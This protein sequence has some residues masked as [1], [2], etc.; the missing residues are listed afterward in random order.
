MP[1]TS[2]PRSRRSNAAVEARILSALKTERVAASKRARGPSPE[3]RGDRARLIDGRAP[4]ALRLQDHVVCARHGD[5]A[6][7]VEGIWLRH[8]SGRGREDLARRLHHPREPS[9]RHPARVRARRRRSSTCCWTTRS[10]MRSASA[11]T[12]GAT[13]CRRRSGS[14]FRSG[15]GVVARLLRY[16][17][18]QPACRPTYA[19]RSG[20]SSA[21]TPIAASIATA[22]STRTGRA[23]PLTTQKGAT[24][25]DDRRIRSAERAR[26]RAP[27][28][29][30]RS[31]RSSIASIRA[32]S[33]SARRSTCEIHVSGGEFNVAA[34]LADCF[35]LKTG[36]A[37]AMVEYP[38]GELIAGARPRDGRHAV[39]QVV[40]ARRR[41]RA[42]HGHRLQR[43]RH[44]VRAP[45]VFY[46]RSN[47][48]GGA[49][50]SRATSTGRR[51]S[52]AGVR[53]FH[54]GGIFAALSDTT[55][56]LIIEGMKAAKAA[57]AV[58]SLRPQ[59]SR[60]AVGRGRRRRARRRRRSAGSSSTSTCWSATKKTC[61]RASASRAGS[62]DKGLGARSSKF[63]GI[64]EKVV[65][66]FP[67]IKV[68]A[69]TLREVHST[70]R[71]AWSAVAG[72]TASSRRADVRARRLRPHRRR[73][74][75]RRRPLLR[76]AHRRAAGG[77]RQAR[78]GPR[79]PAHHL[80]RRHHDGDARTGAGL[81]QGRIGQDSAIKFVNSQLPALQLPGESLEVWG[82]R[83]PASL[84]DDF[85]P[86]RSHP[87]PWDWK[88]E[89]G[90]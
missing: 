21:R 76:A 50:S 54:S 84:L 41:A 45:V 68:V 39:L 70:N 85:H 87:S 46:N 89:V 11:R 1:S 79:R 52:A 9:R 73:R 29:S 64:I 8:R 14:A 74:R 49:C 43:P 67:R 34:N 47:E 4:G 19:R 23:T 56:E 22:S 71:H 38:I 69:T 62:R 83:R 59:L 42:E 33:R 10:A 32:S 12:A 75:L 30:S 24:N 66:N 26:P 60:E 15:H 36:V 44:G 28:T 6:H 55:S 18:E 86:A 31:G 25:T 58:V 7:R 72:S 40:R 63:F 27:S 90:S 77:R 51:S 61:R 65:K 17:T 81:C 20:T 78:L 13:R 88:L 35:G 53:W 82:E 5:A 48:A 16:R 80:P 3:G 2:A 57:G 37:T